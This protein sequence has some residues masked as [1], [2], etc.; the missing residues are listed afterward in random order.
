MP[1]QAMRCDA[2]R[3]WAVDPPRWLP[4]LSTRRP[5]QRLCH[6]RSSSAAIVHRQHFIHTRKLPVATMGAESWG[7]DRNSRS[8]RSTTRPTHCQSRSRSD[9]WPDA[10]AECA[11]MRNSDRSQCD[12]WR[13]LSS[14][15]AV[16][17]ESC[18][19]IDRSTRSAPGD[20]LSARAHLSG[21]VDAVPLTPLPVCVLAHAAPSSHL[22]SLSA[23]HSLSSIRR[24]RPP[25]TSF[26]SRLCH[27]PCRPS[28]WRT[29]C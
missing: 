23:A 11:P 10:A 22:L 13:R 12:S 8:S 21:C 17:S 26:L 24:T 4:A 25:C 2:T 14:R 28:S 3:R 27:P 16:V 20:Q 18:G 19:T 5:A 9:R 29:R 15:C 7:D 6:H 1:C